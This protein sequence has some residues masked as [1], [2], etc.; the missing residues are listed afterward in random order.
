MTKRLQNMRA[1]W[2]T[3]LLV[4]A[5]VGATSAQ[6]VVLHLRDG[7]QISGWI[8]SENAQQVVISNTWT[9]SLSIPVSDIAKREVKEMAMAPPSPKKPTTAPVAPK[10]KSSPTKVAIAKPVI[11]HPN[12]PKGTWHGQINV[13]TSLILG[14]TD[15]EDYSGHANLVYTR[16]YQSDPKKF[17]RNTSDLGGEYQKTDGVES[18]NNMHGS[19]KSDFD[20]WKRY[21]AYGYLGAGYDDIQNIDFQYEV[22]PGG[23]AHLIQD[24]NFSLNTEL[25]VTYQTQYNKNAPNLETFYARLAEDFTWEI[26]K[27][28]KLTENVAFY[29]D[30]E[31]GGQYH[32]DFTTTLSYGFW[33]HLTLNLTVADHYNTEL[34]AGVDPNEF[35]FRSSLGF[36]F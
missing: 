18:A 3:L 12:K 8:L 29:P 34:A 2:L 36:T 5:G 24:P 13:G 28:L 4:C 33:K 14:Q 9:K 1:G 30:F 22:G 6:N 31:R 11:Q 27:N 15:Q 7:D 23:G 17:F 21:Y 20:L 16:P 10:P 25:G 32:N 35:D 19:N 26:E